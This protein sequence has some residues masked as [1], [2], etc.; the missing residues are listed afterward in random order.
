MAPV[1]APLKKSSKPRISKKAFFEPAK[2]K[3]VKINLPAKKPMPVNVLKKT[4]GSKDTKE[5]KKVAFH[6][7]HQ[8]VKEIKSSS[9]RYQKHKEENTILSEAQQAAIL[10]AQQTNKASADRS[11]IEIMEAQTADTKKFDK[12]KFK[13]KLDEKIRATIKSKADAKKIGSD[14]VD[15]TTTKDIGESLETEKSKAGGKVESSTLVPPEAPKTPSEE[16]T[17]LEPV[18]LKVLK[19][20]AST[21]TAHRNTLSPSKRPDS[22]TDFTKETQVL[23][24]TYQK[25]RLSQ[26]QLQ[27]SN[28]P[29]FIKADDSKQESQ[30]KAEALTNE[31]RASESKTIHA[32]R[33]S[34][35]KAMNKT[36]NDM[37]LNHTSINGGRLD[38]QS[39]KSKEE[40][41]I[42]LEV[43]T[44]LDR[45]FA[46]TNEKV[47]SYFKGIDDYVEKVFGYDL[48]KNLDKF[49][50]RVADLL[51]EN[52]GILNHIGAAVTGNDLMSEAQIFDVAKV[53]F[54]HDMQKPIDDLVDAV[55]T[56]MSLANY[57]IKQ[58]HQEKDKFWSKQSK[59]TKRIAGDIMDDTT[60]KFQE[61]ESSVQSKEE[62][63]IDTVTEKFSQA[64]DELDSR[65]AKAVEENKSWLDRAID[66]VK[67][68]INT[69]IEL[70][71]ALVA[72]AQK[73]AAYAER[74]MD[75]PVEF[76][77]NLSDGVGKGFTNFKNNIDKHLV[78]GVLEWL[79]GS[80]AGSEIELPKELNLEGITSLV[81]QILG[82][83]VKKIK[84]L[85]I[86]IIGKERFEF[87]EKGVDASISAGNKILDM[88]KILNEKGLTGLW[89][90]I[91][92]EFSNLKEMLIENVKT[93]VVETI[94]QKA[95]EYVLSLLIPGAG[96]IRA[97]QLLIKF[98]ITLFQKAAQILKIIEGIINTFGDILNKNVSVVA[99]KVEQVFS[100]FLSLAISF[101]AAVLGLNGIVAKVQK[102][103][104]QKIRPKIDAV[105]NKIAMKI[106]QVIE[107]IGL[108][109]LI[110]K[111]MQLVNKGKA[112]VEEK[113]KKAIETGKA[114]V[115]KLVSF[116][117]IK[118]KIKTNDGYH[119]LYF[120]GSEEAPVLMVAS[121]PQTFPDFLKGRGKMD[122]RQTKA[123]ANAEDEFND[124]LAT[125]SKKNTEEKDSEE[126]QK[127]QVKKYDKVTGHVNKL[128][129]YVITLMNLKQLGE[130][131]LTFGGLTA[132]GFGKKM[133]IENLH[134]STRP[135]V[136]S[137]PGV[138][139]NGYNVLSYK[140]N[141]S[142]TYFILGHLLNHNLGGSGND[143]RNLTP[144]TRKGNKD[145]NVDIEET[146]KEDLNAGKVINYTVEPVYTKNTLKNKP[147]DNKIPKYQK[148]VIEMEEKTPKSVKYTYKVWDID[149]EAG[150]ITK[151]DSFKNELDYNHGTYI[152]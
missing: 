43:S 82:I 71:N 102:F 37:L 103:I 73:A 144:L 58:G 117:S 104:Q 60:L 8:P 66:A 142:S 55:D 11:H 3:P 26:D 51:D 148:E 107:K 5:S 145:H 95:V 69:I 24:D 12:K 111:S 105:L 138:S 127:E 28:E 79:T 84:E 108:L 75:D 33:N 76:F 143:F 128:S 42:R 123:K 114:V 29:S 36:Y 141:G 2:K 72:V 23:D 62:A 135:P 109:K 81:M 9:Q 147:A 89:E 53:E 59:E 63:V 126:Y 56:Y 13:D 41:R 38:K 94:T 25:H 119:S 1:A 122:A 133:E 134:K 130:F 125:L 64:L 101:L 121:V 100:G 10:T 87:I 32:T 31:T 67:A 77:G 124:L 83:S 18:G 106:K 22:E 61:L 115:K 85:V 99:D 48:T 65:F 19:P 74:I 50:S 6:S 16:Y 140:R 27:N 110:D 132:D 4:K 93:F 116:F 151:S 118:K 86:N 7:L 152:Q 34:S 45:I 136:G 78:K 15:E 150:A 96:F 14:G 139:N 54:I 44:E 39:E 52:T 91:K 120:E 21:A 90:F 17:T 30:A 137:V 113:K 112:W 68:V 40:N 46:K 88:F 80:M 131:K 49:S 57:A 20:E 98:V 92:E 97:A 146:V 129:N 70:K 47:L 149:D 35:M